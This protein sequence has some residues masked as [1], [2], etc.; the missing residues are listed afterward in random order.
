MA[1]IPAVGVGDVNGDGLSD[2]IYF[3]S[4]ETAVVLSHGTSAG[5]PTEWGG[6]FY[7]AYGNAM[8]KVN[9]DN[10]ADA[11]SFGSDYV[12]VMLSEG[13][14]FGPSTPW[15]TGPFNGTHG[16]ALG[17][18]NGDGLANLVAFDSNATYVM[19][20]NGT[21]AFG[22]QQTWTTVPF[23]GTYGTVLGDVNGDKLDDVV[24]FNATNTYVMLS[25]GSSFGPPLEWS[26]QAF[27]GAYTGATQVAD[28]DGN[29]K[30]DAVGFNPTNTYAELEYTT[31]G[32]TPGTPGDIYAYFFLWNYTENQVTG[33]LITSPPPGA[34]FVGH[35][36]EWILEWP[37][38]SSSAGINNSGLANYHEA[39]L[40]NPWA[41]D[42]N[43]VTYY[44]DSAT[45]TVI[46]GYNNN[47]YI[48]GA[49]LSCPTPQ[50]CTI[51]WDWQNYY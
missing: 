22:P 21:S 39:F 32:L 18:V 2:A 3:T 15:T 41:S 10:N 4:K 51:N 25:N 19:L 43:G 12:S 1:T 48:S 47:D 35:Q 9:R 28:L 8:G 23:Y 29:G 20:S 27:Y 30:A 5:P 42:Y 49:G 16:S 26:N 46:N 11:V 45:S 24:G 50:E 40:S 14:S 17:D 34:S 31:G 44:P 13:G 36:A 38:G 33:T 6:A 7:G 37:S